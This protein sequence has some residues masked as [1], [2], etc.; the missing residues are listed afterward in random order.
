MSINASKIKELREKT[1]AGILDCKSALTE[2]QN[3][4]Q[5]AID[6]LR[7]KGLSVAAKKSG[8]VAAEGLI[9]TKI[10]N[11]KGCIVEINSETDFVSR[12]E[13]F[14]TFVKNCASLAIYSGGNVEKLNEMRY[15]DSENLV[16]EELT[17][18]IATIGENLSIRRIENI[19]LD[20]EG[21]IVSYVHNAVN[22]NLGK[23]G[24][25]I[26][27]KSKVDKEILNDIGKKIAMQIAATNPQSINIENLDKELVAK[28]RSILLEQAITSGKPKD[29]AEKM[30]EGRIKKFYQEVVLE[31]QTFIIDGKTSV[32]QILDDLSNSA[33]DKIE[34]FD[35]K[36][37]V[38]GE[39]I[40][41]NE[42][43]FAAE[44]AATVNQ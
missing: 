7:K 19:T 24:V 32:K 12:N 33:G 37:L 25:L 13:M 38:L 9:A 27:L 36:K 39:G 3:D 22:E 14:Q 21:I 44:V 31:E 2:N 20:G 4:L 5:K 30:V 43:D 1:G 28:E 17:K 6:W 8:R 34:I 42:K 18:N 29:I 11:N 23:I 35:F 15:M 10:E 26:A 41:I 40:D 16:K